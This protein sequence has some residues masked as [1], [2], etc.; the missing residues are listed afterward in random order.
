MTERTFAL[1]VASPSRQIFFGQVSEL[2]VPG[3]AGELQIL[4][5][6]EPLISPLVSGKIA[7]TPEGGERIALEI[8][9]GILEVA[10]NH[11]SVLL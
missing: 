7:Y 4:A 1:R 8:S 3:V 5:N 6:H 9:G 2:H 10:H 11:C